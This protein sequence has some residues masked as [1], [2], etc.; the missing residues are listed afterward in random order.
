ML[1]ADPAAMTMVNPS[2]TDA[3][4]SL[5]EFATA[6]PLGDRGLYWL[7]VRAANAAG[8]DKLRLDERVEWTNEREAEIKAA[9]VNPH[10]HP[11]WAE[12]EHDDPWALLA[13]CYELAEAWDM[14]GAAAKF[15]SRLPVPLDCTCSGIQHFAGLTLDRDMAARVNLTQSNEFTDIYADV[16]RLISDA[17]RKSNH[18]P[19]ADPKS[20]RAAASG[21]RSAKRQSQSRQKRPDTTSAALWRDALPDPK[22]VRALCKPAVMT[23]SYGSGKK[24]IKAQVKTLIRRGKIEIGCTTKPDLD[25]CV[26]WMVELLYDERHA[27]MKPALDV[28]KW[29]RKLAGAMA[30]PIKSPDGI[31]TKDASPFEW[32]TP[33]GS[34]CRQSHFLTVEKRTMTPT[35]RFVLHR[36]PKDREL[37]CR[38]QQT[39]ASP[40]YIH[41]FDAAY[42]SR[43]VL[44]CN[45]NGMDGIAVIHDS[46][47]VHACDTDA[48]RVVMWDEFVSIYETDWLANLEAAIP[49]EALAGAKPLSRPARGTFHLSRDCRPEYFAT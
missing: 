29:L 35:G 13:T 31:P 12:A 4:R 7:K 6:K 40:N 10:L 18:P 32:N 16:G 39:G 42:L 47:G 28:M 36:L 21:P 25:K 38:K 14:P 46:F 37:N 1:S 5:I 8:Q 30:D 22:A 27:V 20:R 49:P 15:L 9:A 41:S 43:V 2:A 34:R 26:E 45:R 11:W 17:L 23:A 48:L 19:A 24:A 33:N 3:G 44:A